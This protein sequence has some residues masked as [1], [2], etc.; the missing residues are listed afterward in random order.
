MN[1][2]YPEYPTPAPWIEVLEWDAGE[3]PVD[4]DETC[5]DGGV[6]DADECVGDDGDAFTPPWG[7]GDEDDYHWY[8]AYLRGHR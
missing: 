6:G 7:S 1:A 3:N 8:G 4:E 5:A 2:D